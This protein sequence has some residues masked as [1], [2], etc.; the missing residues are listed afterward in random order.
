MIKSFHPMLAV[1]CPDDLTQIKFPVLCSKKLDGIR[2]T[3]QGGILV[4]RTLKPIP[5]KYVQ[6]MFKG[7]PDGTD[8]ELIAGDPCKPDA[9]RNTTSVVMSHNRPAD[10]AGVMG[11][12]VFD[13][14]RAGG[15]EERLNYAHIGVDIAPTARHATPVQHTLISCVE[16]L[17]LL[18]EAWVK[19]G[20]EGVMIRSIDGPYKEG[21]STENE[22]YLLKLKRFEDAEARVIGFEEEQKNTNPA[23]TNLLG[24]TE[25]STA[26]AGMKGKG[27]LGKFLC[28]GLNGRYE[29]VEFSVGGGLK[30]AERKAF[31]ALRDDLPGKIVK[32]KYFAKG[33]KDAPRFP[34]YLGLR[35]EEDM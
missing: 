29:G 30:A 13:Q 5:N 3:V 14:F 2:C 15:F 17:E 35:D 34:G 31:W 25:R 12:Y 23:M 11:Y 16:D 9:F 27:S 26:K 10:F 33:G 32:Y 22:G 18:E 24:R 28:V 19:E 20:Y 4:S 8:G 7:L 1:P 21:R 6:A